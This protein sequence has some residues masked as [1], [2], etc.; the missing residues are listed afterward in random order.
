MA[1]RLSA[2]SIN[3]AIEHLAK[4]GD[5]D[6]FPHLPEILFLNEKKDAVCAE[7]SALDLDGFNPAQA[8]ETIAPKSRYGFRIVQQMPLLETLLFTASLIEIGADLEIIKRPLDEDGPFAYR[9][10][11]SGDSSLFLENHTYRDWLEWQSTKVERGQYTHVICTDIADYYQRIYLHRIENTLDAATANKGVKRFIEKLIKQIRSKQSYGIPVGCAASRIIAE[12]VLADSDNALADSEIEF[13]RFVDD[14]RIFVTPGQE[15][16]AILAFLADQLAAGEGLSLNA[17]KTKLHPIKEFKEHLEAQ[18]SREFFD[19]AG[20]DAIQALS[21][22]FYFDEEI[23]ESDI[24]KLRALN[25][26]EMLEKELA[27]EV[28]DF[29]K[30]KAIFRALRLV[31][32]PNCVE[33]ITEKFELFLPFIRDLVLYLDELDQ[34]HSLD[35]A[36]LRERVLSQIRQ[37]AASSV[38]TIRVWLLEL[39]VRDVMQISTKELNELRGQETLDNRQIDLIRG[40]NGDVNYFRRQKTRFDER[41]LFEKSAFMLGATCLPKDEFETWIGAIRPN[42]NRPLEKLFCDWVKTKHHGIR[43]VI[44]ARFALVRE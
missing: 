20:R 23:P 3:R 27:E 4:F 10:A 41:N 19:E 33:F 36:R 2:P 25:L 30:I 5:T 14:Y 34:H 39:F 38:S 11:S 40:L 31:P 26:L 28:W 15:P 21:H 24:S 17:Q 8:I 9:F 13:T 22:A 44:D 37:G 6:V 16:Y 35:F 43:S 32:D 29:G 18:L 7:L 1:T 12:S 42:M